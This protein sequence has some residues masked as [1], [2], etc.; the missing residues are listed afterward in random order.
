MPDPGS[1]FFHP[2]S[3]DKKIPD[4]DPHQRIEVF[5]T[6]KLFLSSRKNYMGCSSRIPDPGSGT[7]FL[8]LLITALLSFDIELH[9]RR[10]N[11]FEIDLI[12]IKF[13]LK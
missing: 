7:L 4:P 10:M 9:G 8:G 3:P 2:G 13:N 6:R 1:V 11:K 5:L 12:Q